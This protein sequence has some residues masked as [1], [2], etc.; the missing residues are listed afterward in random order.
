MNG[1]TIDLVKVDEENLSPENYL[2]LDERERANIISTKIIPSR[3]GKSDFGQ[4]RVVYRTPTYKAA[5]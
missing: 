3:L 4:I 2:K 1:A 5:R